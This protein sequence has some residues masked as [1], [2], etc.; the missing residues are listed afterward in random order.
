M[1][2][3]WRTQVNN[4][5][6]KKKGSCRFSG[7]LTFIL[8]CLLLIDASPVYALSLEQEK[9]M[10][11]QFAFQVSRQLD[12]VDDDFAHRYINSLGQYLIRPLETKP[13]PF[14]F[15]N[16][17][18]KALNAFA[19]PGG[20]IYVFS[21]LV[22]A[23]D[24]L[25]ELVAVLCHEIGHV[26]AR[27]IASRYAQS[28]KIGMAT[29]VG[30]LAGV[31][32]GVA[33]GGGGAGM[34]V[35]MGSLAAGQQAHL[36]Y[37]RV[38]ERQADQISFRLMQ[39]TGFNPE[40]MIGALTKIGKSSWV[41]SGNVPTYLLTHPAGTERMSNFESMLTG[42]SP[43]PQ[44]KEAAMYT[45]YFPYFQ[46]IM[47]ARCHDPQEAERTFLREVEENPKSFL[48]HFGLALI[49]KQSTDFDKA[50][51][52][53]YKAV[54]RKKDFP[55]LLISLGKL[56]QLQGEYEAAIPCYEKAL[57]IE[58]KNREALFLLGEAYRHMEEY[59]KS[60]A[61]FERLVNLKPVKTEVF[62]QLGI[63]YGRQDKLLLAHYNFGIYYRRL[64]DA[65]RAR[66]HF[67]KAQKLAGN[68]AVLRE[69]IQKELKAIPNT[70]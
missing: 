13:F 27:H 33:G 9:K 26:S 68:D 51:A 3:S 15:Y 37:S 23:V 29:M 43:P 35:A 14:R 7:L 44:T 2:L 31:V 40:G 58:A 36:N 30:V 62:Q 16:V 59:K 4:Y 11:Q 39:P 64:R 60:V 25:D 41:G 48:P 52:H 49:Y 6:P 61:I 22:E 34:G 53:F 54:E 17:N 56:H 57:E 10:G 32:A 8:S 70:R 47:R 28:K 46:T 5:R 19:G 12:L 20:H 21:G 45:S 42:Y 65:D 66:F 38:A 69:R 1:N 24:T 50:E 63:A 18:H 67:E 55:P